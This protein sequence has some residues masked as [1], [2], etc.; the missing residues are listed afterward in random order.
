MNH[1]SNAIRPN[2][3]TKYEGSPLP[4][5]PQFNSGT[6]QQATE[7]S[8]ALHSCKWT[9][10][11]LSSKVIGIR[12]N[13]FFYFAWFSDEANPSDP[14]ELSFDK[15]DVLEIID[16]RGN[17]W[18]ARKTDGTTG[19]VPSNYVSFTLSFTW[20]Q[21]IY[22]FICYDSSNRSYQMIQFFKQRLLYLPMKYNEYC[23]SLHI[24]Y[25]FIFILSLLLLNKQT[26][27]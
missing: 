26:N 21:V 15:G 9:L 14:Q 10:L 23:L 8:T 20:H 3:N 4:P 16:K 6:P 17:W 25:I 5:Q 11:F 7:Q 22:I 12:F 13:F 24:K 19:I 18:Q 27:K 2:S 1:I